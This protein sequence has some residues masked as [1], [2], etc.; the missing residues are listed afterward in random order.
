[1]D[2]NTTSQPGIWHRT[3]FG[4]RVLSPQSP[5]FVISAPSSRQHRDAFRRQAL[6]D[7]AHLTQLLSES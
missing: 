5:Y 6:A 1:M 4:C 2:E 7:L 3:G